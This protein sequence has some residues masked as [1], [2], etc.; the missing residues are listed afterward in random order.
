L[1]AATLRAPGM[2]ASGFGNPHLAEMIIE[3]AM[4]GNVVLTRQ[5]RSSSVRAIVH[6]IGRLA[7]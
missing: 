3:Y 1:L 5:R 6:T 2:R 4:T 7:R